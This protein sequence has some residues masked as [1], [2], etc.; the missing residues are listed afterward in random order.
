MF[1]MQP[2]RLRPIRPAGDHRCAFTL[3][4]LLVVISIIAILIALLLP[5]L[6]RAKLQAESTVCLSNLHSLGE[7]YQEYFVEN[8]GLIEVTNEG[9][10]PELLWPYINS[11]QAL[12]PVPPAEVAAGFNYPVNGWYAPSYLCP[13]ATTVLSDYTNQGGSQCTYGYVGDSFHAS[14][15]E[16]IDTT[17]NQWTGFIT[18]YMQNDWIG[19]QPPASSSTWIGGSQMW[20]HI[21]NAKDG[22]NIP[23]IGDGVW[24]GVYPFWYGKWV[25]DPPRELPAASAGP[26]QRLYP[27]MN[28]CLVTRHP[29][30]AVNWAFADGSARS[31][32]FEDLWGLRWNTIY[33]PT[34]RPALPSVDWGNY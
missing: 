26:V 32:K 3:V 11:A 29:G 15:S 31:V 25:T 28:R 5:A 7:A 20:G 23:L 27:M 2:A 24:F 14:A 10:W 34:F 1:I 8:K 18:S 12:S 19:C 13:M 6:A 9:D 17:S 16:L 22:S 30:E 21:A 33:V 4:E